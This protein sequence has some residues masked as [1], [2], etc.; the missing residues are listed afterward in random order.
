MRSPRS[1]SN[2]SCGT[3]RSATRGAATSPRR[4]RASTARSPTLPEAQQDRR[5]GAKHRRHAA[6]RALQGHP[7]LP[8]GNNIG[9]EGCGHLPRRC[10]ASTARSPNSTC[11]TT[12]SAPRGAAT[13]PRRCRASTARSPNSTWGNNI[14]ARVR[15]PR[16][17]AAERALQGHQTPPARNNIGDEGCGHL[18]KAL[19]SSTARSPNSSW[20]TTTSA[21]CGHPKALQSEHCKVTQLNLWKTTSA[22][23]WP[24]RQG[25]AERNARSPNSPGEQQHRRRGVRPPR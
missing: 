9:A 20:I 4:C 18:A 19:Q 6:E 16:Q 10:R 7:T 15:P 11:G 24:P 13:S 2:S 17:G 12:T 21:R 25:A 14:G 23:R 22:P 1:D 5:R 8:G 3:T